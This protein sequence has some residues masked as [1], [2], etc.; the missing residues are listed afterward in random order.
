MA[1][2]YAAVRDCL[3]ETFGGASPLNVPNGTAEVQTTQKWHW[4][5]SNSNGTPKTE[6]YPK[7]A[8]ML[9]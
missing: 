3:E 6:E 1:V 2:V 9:L 8:F 5:V 4:H 7:T